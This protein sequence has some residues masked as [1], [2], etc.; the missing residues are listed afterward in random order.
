MMPTTINAERWDDDANDEDNNNQHQ[1]TKAN[2]N[3]VVILMLII[4]PIRLWLWI[5]HNN[6]T[7]NDDHG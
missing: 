7:K 6:D 3:T 1:I 5:A 4:T 2:D